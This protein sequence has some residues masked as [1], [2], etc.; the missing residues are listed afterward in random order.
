MSNSFNEKNMS[1]RVIGNESGAGALILTLITV[2]LL[3]LIIS[4]MPSYISSYASD[5][6]RF[7]K[8]TSALQVQNSISKLV[9]DARR[10]G[11]E[12]NENGWTN[13][14]N[15]NSGT[16]TFKTAYAGAANLMFCFPQLTG[17]NDPCVSD[18]SGDGSPVCI[19]EVTNGNN[20]YSMALNK[21]LKFDFIVK[22]KRD[23]LNTIKHK[24]LIAL[25]DFLID[26]EQTNL[27]NYAQAQSGVA[28]TDNFRPANPQSTVSNDSRAPSCPNA[29]Q[30]LCQECSTTSGRAN[31]LNVKINDDKYGKVYQQF[32]VEI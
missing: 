26:L 4:Q 19:E 18:D 32:I 24:S 10:K 15:H 7:R 3:S 16:K 11:I 21:G 8:Q 22:V 28:V 20:D 25:H 14:N 31:C 29:S 23:K 1:P 30:P 6:E 17:A 13:C 9:L 12:A 2:V 5:F 27:I